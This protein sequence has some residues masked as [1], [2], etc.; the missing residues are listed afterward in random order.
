M[1]CWPTEFFEILRQVLA[2]AGSTL[3]EMT[4]GLSSF[5]KERQTHEVLAK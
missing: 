3:S 4:F 5:K 1:R 2:L